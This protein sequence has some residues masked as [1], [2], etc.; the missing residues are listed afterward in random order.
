MPDEQRPQQ[1][2]PASR[3][4]QRDVRAVAAAPDAG[5]LRTAYLELLKLCLCDL[6][7]TA[8]TSVWTHTDGSLMSREL[9]GEEL[10]IRAAGVD[11]PLHGFTM[12]GLHRLDDLQ[13]CVESVLRD[14]VAGDLIEAGSW[15]GGAAILMRATLDALGGGRTV[16]VAD[17]FQGFPAP[18]DDHPDRGA[19]AP[20]DYLA[21]PEADVRANF[22]R[23]GYE[24]GVSFLPGFFEDTL[25][26]LA[27]RRW[28]VVR[29]DGDSYEATRLAL[30]SLYPGLSVGGHLIVDDYGALAECRRAVDEFRAEHG[31]AEPLEAVD[32]TCVRWRRTSDAAIEPAQAPG[33]HGAANGRARARPLERDPGARIVSMY[34]RALKRDVRHMERE[35]EALR[36]R[37]AAAEAESARCAA[38]RCAACVPGCAS[39]AAAGAAERQ[40]GPRASTTLWAQSRRTTGVALD[41]RSSA[42][43]AAPARRAARS[44]APARAAR[45]RTIVR[46]AGAQPGQH[47]RLGDQPLR[48]RVLRHA[49]HEAPQYGLRGLWSQTRI[50]PPGRVTRA[51]SASVCAH[52]AGLGDVVQH[53]HAST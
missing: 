50:R 22:A 6:A 32:W 41:R 20:I 21:V 49:R 44:P 1:A 26:G 35:L 42:A 12:V 47:L 24:R 52:G 3:R 5:G 43:A 40:P 30:Q 4:P 9:A 7:G 28:S 53:G 46:A 14:D 34:E 45:E 48:A 8:T 25:P 11:W 15:R 18:D 38:R 19:L 10:Q 2:P 27:G 37:L 13:A 33:G 17:S 16:W 31:I 51:I 29:L 36:E 23:L 39:A